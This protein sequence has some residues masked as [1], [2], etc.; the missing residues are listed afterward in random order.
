M[1]YGVKM[2]DVCRMSDNKL[3]LLSQQYGFCF[4]MFAALFIRPIDNISVTRMGR[5][6]W[7]NMQILVVYHRL[8]RS[9][10]LTAEGES[11]FISKIFR[12]YLS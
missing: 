4:A 7:N 11:F 1:L 3:R 8:M 5:G 9:S 10:G 2:N 12:Q 6:M